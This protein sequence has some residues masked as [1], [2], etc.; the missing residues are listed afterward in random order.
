MLKKVEGRIGSVEISR[1]YELTFLGQTAQDFF[2][3]FRWEAMER[4]KHW[5]CP[6]YFD[7]ESGRIPMDVQSFVLRTKH[8]VVMIDTC[9]GNHKER[10]AVP[11]FHQLNTGYMD[12]LAE[13]GLGPK[14]VDYVMCTHLH[15]DHI[16]WN[17][18]LVDGRWV[19]TFPNARY[20]VS[21]AEFETA[22][23][24][25]RTTKFA[26][27]RDGWVDSVAPIVAAGLMD[28]VEDRHEVL[29]MLTV[30]PGPGHTKNNVLFELNSD[31]ERALFAGDMLHSP[32]Q[33]PYWQWSSK[34]CVD[35]KLAAQ[36]RR[37]LL[38][39]CVAENALMIPAHFLAPHVGRIRED[40][41]T[42]AIKWGW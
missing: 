21:R 27:T 41:D 28:Y 40:G 38:E 7:A 25:A 17:T 42:F 8:H 2:P 30:R 3:D 29:D 4:H 32:I 37:E 24:E 39:R 14:D 22:E 13:L 23:A 26:P 20:L 15:L 6:T 5:L 10:V 9:C 35:P 18:R 33:I 12:R 34:L 31:G 11:E 19:P 36:S 1:I 16:G